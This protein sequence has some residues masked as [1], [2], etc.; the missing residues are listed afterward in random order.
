MP[1]VS[2]HK[3]QSLEL[4]AL[5]PYRTLRRPQTHLHQG[6]FVAEGEKVVRRF[7]ASD[8][9]V[10]SL[11]LTQEWLD[12]LLPDIDPSRL[13]SIDVFVGEKTLLETIVGFPLHQGIMAVGKVP[14]EQSPEEMIAHLPHPHFLVALD[15]LVHAENVGVVV[16]NCAGFGVD[17]ILVSTT[18]ASPYLRRAVRNSM[19][20]VFK[21]PVLHIENL[22]A[23]LAWLKERHH[24]RIIIA[25]AHA[26][27]TIHEMDFGGNICIVFGNEDAG[28]SE[29][30]E[31]TATDH[32]TIPMY[33]STD[34]L[35]VASAS[36]VMLYEARRRR[37]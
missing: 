37:G 14:I 35:N 36:A 13:I 17:G 2:V 19:G 33:K 34:S 24:A 25:D 15:G 28:V 21:T 30:V 26:T 27:R 20:G 5:L 12:A 7:L 31:A 32:V 9:K 16:R 29:K 3:I 18:S 10:I 4:P 11:L 1:V 23:S 6:I 22:A 8:W